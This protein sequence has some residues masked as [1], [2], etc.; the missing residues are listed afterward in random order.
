[1]VDFIAGERHFGDHLYPIW[2]ALPANRR[3]A[4][5]LPE[6]LLEPAEAAGVAA[7]P[8]AEAGS[9]GLTVVASYSD[10]K[11]ARGLGR[12][13]VYCEHGAGQSYVGVR[14]GSYIGALDRAGVVATL[15]PGRD[16]ARRHESVHPAIR[17]HPIGCPKLDRH[18]A[19]PRSLPD[20]AVV[21]I[22][23]HWNCRV[24]RETQ[25]AYR[26]YRGGLR[27]LAE[28]FE[29]IGHGHP[30]VLG[31]LR[32]DYEGAGIEVVEDFE[33]VIRRASVYCVDN[34]STLY[35]WAALD[36]PAV[37]LNAPWFRRN[38]EHGLRFWSHADVGPQVW[39]PGSLPAAIEA[40]LADPP[41]LAERR[42]EIVRDVY[43]AGD[44]KAARRAAAALAQIGKEWGWS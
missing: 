29:V 21:A 8:L 19:S 41:E 16:A 22:S 27:R 20:G 44:G 26:H 25:G 14:S 43:L 28:R 39:D 36:R 3:G 18:H 13:V 35:E 30:R 23:F 9:G 7:F 40:A 34:S 42:R 5:Y 1:M 33:E 17:A 15:V 11:V 10:L 38:V 24:C 32:R 37:V 12:R 4:F 6:Q 2:N 31:Q